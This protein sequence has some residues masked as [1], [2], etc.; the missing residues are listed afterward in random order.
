MYRVHVTN[1]KLSLTTRM[2]TT[3]RLSPMPDE[4]QTLEALHLRM[5]FGVRALFYTYIYGIS[6]LI[7]TIRSSQKAA[8]VESAKRRRR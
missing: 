3:Q 1:V 8:L 7:F 5:Q 4:M 6:N 2:T